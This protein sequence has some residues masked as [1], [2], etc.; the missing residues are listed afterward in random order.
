[1]RFFARIGQTREVHIYRLVTEHSIE[2][3]ILLKARQKRNLDIMVMDRGNFTTAEAEKPE[4]LTNADVQDVYSK[5]GLREILGVS[6]DGDGMD[7]VEDETLEVAEVSD[8]KLSSEQI[9]KTMAS[10]EDADDAEA[11]KGARQE[12]ADEL[13]EF[14]ESIEYKKDSDAEEPDEVE[15]EV[16]AEPEKDDTKELEQQIASWQENDGMDAATIEA[17][18]TAIERYGLRLRE[19]IDPYESVFAVLHQRQLE[20][21]KAEQDNEI[22]IGEIERQ[23][24]LD[25]QKA[26]ADGDLLCT[27][28]DPHDLVRLRDLYWREKSRLAANKLMRRLTGGDWEQKKDALTQNRYWYNIDTGEATWTT[29]EVIVAREEYELAVT[30]GWAALPNKLLVNVMGFLLPYP[31]RTRCSRTCSRW[32]R[33]ATDV[34]FVRHIYPVEQGAY[35]REAHKIDPNHYRTIADAMLDALP[36]DTIGASFLL[37]V[38]CALD[39]FVRI[40][41][42]CFIRKKTEF[43]DGH[44]F[45]NTDLLVDVPLRFI[46]DEHNP[47]N[48]VV[49]MSG[50]IQWKASGGYIEGMLWRRPAMQA[51]T[52][53]RPMLSLIGINREAETAA[54][55]LIHSVLDNNGTDGAVVTVSASSVFRGV[56]SVIQ[57]GAVGVSVA[58]CAAR[59]NLTKVCI[60]VRVLPIAG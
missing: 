18:L 12:V 9:E 44:F 47:A 33:A 46:G 3:N 2:E 20:E 17:S 26:F 48:V 6:K 24:E 29:P 35:T 59:V 11:L 54:V 60:I 40:T 14:D 8:G 37:T 32:K 21:T 10:L 56:E 15:K 1:M 31:D 39:L 43:A 13:K 53:L 52:S 16:T 36:G 23:N 51:E 27:N 30:E 5:G 38:C 7:I 49:E 55:K 41:H 25:E 50:T 58:G 57:N 19:E 22:D 42:I 4:S 34:S 45:H 28:P